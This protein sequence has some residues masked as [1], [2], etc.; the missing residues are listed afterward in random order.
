RQMIEQA[1]VRLE[2]PDTDHQGVAQAIED[3]Y[4]GLVMLES[5]DPL[6]DEATARL[7][8][9]ASEL[10][11]QWLVRNRAELWRTLV[12]LPMYRQDYEHTRQRLDQA[13]MALSY[14][15]GPGGEALA[16]ASYL[17]DVQ[18][19]YWAVSTGNFAFSRDLL[20]Q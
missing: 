6:W 16:E 17:L 1:L 10:Q 19:L 2:R 13:H 9:L 4:R 7:G 3:V 14:E 11:T 5:G 15:E 20:A 8:A 12:R 18:E